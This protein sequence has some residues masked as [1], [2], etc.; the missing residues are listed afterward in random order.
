MEA[1]PLPAIPGQLD[2]D[3][4]LE[5]VSAEDA[6]PP[7]APASALGAAA[8]RF[9]R[10]TLR[11]SKQTQ[12]TYLSV[13]S[14]FAAHL[15][16]LTGVKDPPPSALSSDVVASYLNMLEAQGRSMATVRKE[17]AALNRPDPASAT[18]RRDR[19]NDRA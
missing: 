2:V 4:V 6:S 13:Y 12:R 16:A 5:L 15:A 10:N 18:D 11:K 14:R 1:E 8:G 3:E 17:R 7:A 9:A 19:P